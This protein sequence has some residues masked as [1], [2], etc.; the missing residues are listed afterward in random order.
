MEEF[1]TFQNTEVVV[2]S[3]K[4][5]YDYTKLAYEN[6]TTHLFDQL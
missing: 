6:Q 3:I 5:D 2:N 1:L 4:I